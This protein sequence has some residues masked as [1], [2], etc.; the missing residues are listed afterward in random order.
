MNRLFIMC[1]S[2]KKY[3]ILILMFA[4]SFFSC[5][6]DIVK[7][8]LPDQVLNIKELVFKTYENQKVE[9]EIDEEG[10]VANLK[11]TIDNIIL[12]VSKSI[13]RKIYFTNHN[14]FNVIKLAKTNT[15]GQGYISNDILLTIGFGYFSENSDIPDIEKI[16]LRDYSLE[17]FISKNSIYEIIIRDVD[18][19]KVVEK[20]VQNVPSTRSNKP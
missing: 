6:N 14:E 9:I 5:A 1:F 10:Y 7:T 13:L 3:Y 20:L 16:K 11:I 18:S 19:D 17:I 8:G 2:T 12:D 4:F 15:E